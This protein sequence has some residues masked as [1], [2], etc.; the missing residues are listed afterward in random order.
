MINNGWMENSAVVLALTLVHSVESGRR[1]TSGSFEEGG[2]WKEPQELRLGC[3]RKGRVCFTSSVQVSAGNIY[4][5][6]TCCCSVS[7]D[8][9]DLDRPRPS[10]P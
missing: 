4:V 8:A 3:L 9:P 6:V 1:W 5:S 7:L 10:L 2:H